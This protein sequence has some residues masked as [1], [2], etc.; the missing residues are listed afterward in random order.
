MDI[1]YACIAQPLS[2]LVICNQ[3]YRLVQVNQISAP[4]LFL[5]PCII[6]GVNLGD[7]LVRECNG[8]ILLAWIISSL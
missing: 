4:Q 7:N 5:F 1:L 3:F 6:L 2:Y 8:R